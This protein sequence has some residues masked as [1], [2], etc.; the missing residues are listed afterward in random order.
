MSNVRNAD[1]LMARLDAIADTIPEIQRDKAEAAAR[2]AAAYNAAFWD[3]M[4]TGMPHNALKEGSDGSGG[5]LVPDTYHDRMVKA[6]A[7]KNVLRQISHVIPTSHRMH[8][9]VAGD[10]DCADW[11]PEN[12]VM[13]FMDAE[14]GEVI[15]DAY[16]LGTTIRASDEMLEDNGIDLEKYILDM[17]SERIGDAEEKAFIRGDGN[18]KPMGLIHQAELGVMSELD[19]NIT[20]DDM[21]NLEYALSSEY[22]D[23]AV[24]LMSEDAYNRLRRIPHYL[25]HGVWRNDLKEGD[26]VRLFGYPIYICHAMDDVAPGNIPVMFGDFS[27]YWIGDR[28][29]RTIKRLVER[30][31]DRGQVAFITT[32]RVDAK[33]TLPKAVKML[34]ISGTP[35][36]EE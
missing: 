10:V 9:P 32:E 25:G 30:Y 11:I 15:L 31:A 19:G 26:P 18:G 36:A 14:F 33:L 21:V 4:H 12:T 35:V 1:E 23:N 28:G 3:T 6:L 22:R 27:N 20:M 16:K 7:K 24:W 5:Y 34:K 8:I 17:F 29:K 13:K 2:K